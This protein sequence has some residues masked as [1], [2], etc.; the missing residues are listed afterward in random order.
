MIYY[1]NN[2]IDSLD[3]LRQATKEMTALLS[4]QTTYKGNAHNIISELISVITISNF[5][6]ELKLQKE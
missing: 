5:T 6:K 3:E 4:Q 1:K 2:A